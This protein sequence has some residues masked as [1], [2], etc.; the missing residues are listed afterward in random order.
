[1]ILSTFLFLY[2]FYDEMKLLAKVK[3]IL[4]IILE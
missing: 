1:M 2:K 4:I 3:N